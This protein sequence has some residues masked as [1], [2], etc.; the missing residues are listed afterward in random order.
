MAKSESKNAKKFKSVMNLCKIIK[1]DEEEAKF[2]KKVKVFK[3]FKKEL[4]EDEVEEDSEKNQISLMDKLI[5]EE[6]CEME[7]LNIIEATE[8]EPT[9]I[10]SYST[11]KTNYTPIVFAASPRKSILNHM[12]NKRK[13]SSTNANAKDSSQIILMV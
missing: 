10:P 9:E 3:N 2:E 5:N 8:D 7:M 13:H 6:G 4:Y 12:E 11:P 1:E